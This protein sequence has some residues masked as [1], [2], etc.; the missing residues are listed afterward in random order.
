MNIPVRASI[1]SSSSRRKALWGHLRACREARRHLNHS[2]QHIA[3]YNCLS[4]LVEK[5]V[6]ASEGH[7]YIRHHFHVGRNSNGTYLFLLAADNLIA[8]TLESISIGNKE[9]GYFEPRA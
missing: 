6:D 4:A 1:S 8:L 5:F 7:E 9:A 2:K 3:R